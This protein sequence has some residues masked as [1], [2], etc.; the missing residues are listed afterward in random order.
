MLLSSTGAYG[1]FG[2]GATRSP[3][4]ASLQR[5][6]VS[7]ALATRDN[8]LA[9]GGTDGLIGPKTVAGVNRALVQYVG[10]APARLRTGKL[11]DNHVLANATVL[12]GLVSNEAARRD[13]AQRPAAPS[14]PVA[15]Q[16]P[17]SRSNPAVA[18]LQE[19]LGA[20]AQLT[21]DVRVRASPDGIVGPKTAA[22]VNRA[23]TKYV[24]AAPNNLKTGRLTVANVAVLAPEL[25]SW[26]AGD[27][28]RRR[29]TSA[30]PQPVPVPMPAPSRGLV[31][32]LQQGMRALADVTRD[33]ALYIST[34]GSVGPGTTRAVNRALQKYVS[35]APAQWRT[36]KLTVNTVK[37]GV[38]ALIP[39]VETAI[40][41]LRKAAAKKPPPPPPPAPKKPT[42]AKP[43]R[44][45]VTQLQRSIYNLGK[46]IKDTRLQIADDGVIGPKTAAAVNYLFTKYI[47]AGEA[48]EQFRTGRLTTASIAG[49]VDT[50]TG[51][52]QQELQRAIDDVQK[53]RDEDVSKQQEE[54]DRLRRDQDARE[55]VARDA[56]PTTPTPEG[57]GSEGDQE[58]PTRDEMPAPPP[59]VGPAIP[60]TVAP[61][62]PPAEDYGPPT[63]DQVAP[64]AD[65]RPAP[66]DNAVGPAPS[67]KPMPWGWIAGIGGGVIVLGLTAYLIWGGK[68]ASAPQLQVRRELGPA[69]TRP[70]PQRKPQRRRVQRQR[71]EPK[72]KAA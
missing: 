66:G 3:A 22:A 72:R 15:A 16:R 24:Q 18:K 71:R 10:N 49:A 31:V 26:L 46:T 33:R 40:A 27:V 43:A 63:P 28:K 56:V 21:R 11:T 59:A 5:A 7:L 2:F 47:T 17:T 53:A 6:L 51:Y 42:V 36:G 13:G 64:G 65:D 61:P 23:F 45:A 12:T 62:P 44:E 54:Q 9:A 1:A 68:G 67:A 55:R 14:A 50:L 60:S 8:T 20:L 30:V 58:G 52:V 35:E 19:W 25:A 32:R 57:R 39:H 69:S 38:A 29:E 70:Q 34:D 4:I 48:P 37:S 41:R